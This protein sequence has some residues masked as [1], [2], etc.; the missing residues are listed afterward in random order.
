MRCLRWIGLY[1]DRRQTPAAA[2]GL[3]QHSDLESLGFS[4]ADARAAEDGRSLKVWATKNS[5]NRE[6]PPP[7]IGRCLLRGHD[8]GFWFR[9]L[10]FR[11]SCVGP[12]NGENQLDLPPETVRGVAVSRRPAVR[13]REGHRKPFVHE[14]RIVK[15]LKMFCLSQ[16]SREHV[17]RLSI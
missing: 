12:G 14:P 6:L 2:W 17:P 9:S 1:C 16:G 15:P 7:A 11:A 8:N 5:D 3:R 10:V 13:C 4:G